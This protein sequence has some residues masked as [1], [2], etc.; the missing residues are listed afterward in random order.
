[1]RAGCWRSYGQPD[2]SVN[3]LRVDTQPCQQW[4]QHRRLNTTTQ[5]R[6]HWLATVLGRYLN[7]LT[8]LKKAIKHC[9]IDLA[10]SSL[11][12]KSTGELRFWAFSGYWIARAPSPISIDTESSPEIVGCDPRGD[13]G[14]LGRL[15]RLHRPKMMAC[16]GTETVSP[17]E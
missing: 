14:G 10:K 7:R 11:P 8:H 17:T 1:M 13:M 16:R 3:L 15:P 5:M 4:M 9:E 6:N 2:G 12:M